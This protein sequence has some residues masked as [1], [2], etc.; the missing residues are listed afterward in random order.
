MSPAWFW[1]LATLLCVGIEAFF[2]MAEMAIISFNKVRLQEYLLKKNQRAMW[3]ESLLKSPSRL[4]GTVLFGVNFA[5]QLGSEC[6]RHFYRACDLDPDWAPLSQFFLVVIFAELA[7]LFAA[8]RAPETVA[9][10]QSP[11][12]YTLSRLLFPVIWCFGKLVH[13]MNWCFGGHQEDILPSVNREDLQKI[14]EEK[15]GH[16]FFLEERTILGEVVSK[17]FDLKSVN[18]RQT[19]IPLERLKMIPDS[20]T[21]GTTRDLI[22]RSKHLIFGVYHRNR[23]NLVHLIDTSKLYAL[24]DALPIKDQLTS[25]LFLNED[26][27]LLDAVTHLLADAH[28]AAIVI[29]REGKPIGMTSLDECMEWLLHIRKRQLNESQVVQCTFAAKKRLKEVNERLHLQLSNEHGDTLAELL[30]FHLGT[31][32]E[33]GESIVLNNCEFTVMEVSVFGIKSVRVRSLPML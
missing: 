23:K 3:I 4:F 11:I 29:D 8:R 28:R 24:D 9:L 33:A 31:H 6:A 16:E 27:N 7:P 14:L 2:S 30:T 15:E 10:W 25:P 1:L 32:P 12:L 26:V 20:A 18:V 19:L 22:K 21:V 5:L 13:F 17:L